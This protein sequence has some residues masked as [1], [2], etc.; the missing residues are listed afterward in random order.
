M[1]SAP[2]VVPVRFAGGGLSMQTTTSRMSTDAAFIRSIVSPKE[3]SSVLLLLTLPG[4]A[5]KPLELHGTVSER[6]ASGGHG[7]EAGFTVMFA[8]LGTIARD[9][10]TAFLRTKGVGDFTRRPI[11]APNPTVSEI[12]PVGSRRTWARVATRLQVGWSSAKEFLVAY[13]ENISRGGIFVSTPNPPPLREVVELLLEL[14]DS[15][16][17]A[18][19]QAEVVQRVTAEEA[20]ATGRTA[21]AGLQFVGADDAFRERLDRCI[22]SLLLG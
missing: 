16:G 22:E 10:M 15:E 6:I 7:K 13:S 18:K 3:G 2:I 4:D 12:E 21:G 9:R 11:P 14:P 19:T 17:P 5:A 1:D 8:D 20:R